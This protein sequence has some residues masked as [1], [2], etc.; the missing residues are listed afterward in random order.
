MS[1][2]GG[3]GAIALSVRGIPFASLGMRNDHGGSAKVLGARGIPLDLLRLLNC[4]VSSHTH[5][6]F[7][8]SDMAITE[9]EGR[10]GGKFCKRLLRRLPSTPYERPPLAVRGTSRPQPANEAGRS[11]W[12]SKLVDSA[13]QIIVEGV[14]RLFSSVFRKGVAST[15]GENINTIEEVAEMI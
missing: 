14:S 8:I 15:P 11:G 2:H 9:D 12:F 5:H 6:H 4:F 1:E 13:A 10:I 3:G 7:S